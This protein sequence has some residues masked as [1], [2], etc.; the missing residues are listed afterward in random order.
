MRDPADVIADALY[1][2]GLDQGNDA[3][4]GAVDVLLALRDEYGWALEHGIARPFIPVPVACGL[5]GGHRRSRCAGR[6]HQPIR[7]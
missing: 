2:L 5:R 6:H 7:P 4:N 3:A 1:R